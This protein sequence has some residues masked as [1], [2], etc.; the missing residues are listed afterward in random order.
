MDP[1]IT[2]FDMDFL[3]AFPVIEATF[4]SLLYED[5]NTHLFHRCDEKM[6][7]MLIRGPNAQSGPVLN[8]SND[9]RPL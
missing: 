5:D 9:H 6:E 7:N 8:Q 4:L 2:N 3:L 1:N